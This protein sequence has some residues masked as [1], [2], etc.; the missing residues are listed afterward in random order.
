MNTLTVTPNLSATPSP[1]PTPTPIPTSSCS[2]YLSLQ[3]QINMSWQGFTVLVLENG[4]DQKSVYYI[5]RRGFGP[6]SS[7]T[8]ENQ[9]HCCGSDT[10]AS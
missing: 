6:G 10:D 1:V 5:Y 8:E 4:R 3:D 9:Y 2:A 7:H